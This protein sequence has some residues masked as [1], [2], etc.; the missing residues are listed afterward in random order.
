M[1]MFINQ[2]KLL[3]LNLKMKKIEFKNKKKEIIEALNLKNIKC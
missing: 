2:T 3:S 1:S